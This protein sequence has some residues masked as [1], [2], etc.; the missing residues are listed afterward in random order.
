MFKIALAL[1]LLLMIAEA[2]DTLADE[3]SR[4]SVKLYF[5]GKRYGSDDGFVTSYYTAEGDDPS[6]YDTRCQMQYHFDNKF[7]AAMNVALCY[8]INKTFEAECGLGY[9]TIRMDITQRFNYFRNAYIGGGSYYTSLEYEDAS[10]YDYDVFNIRPGLNLYLTSGPRFIPYI[11]AR[12]DLKIIR[13]DAQL[14]F[15]KPY[16]TEESGQYYLFIGQEADVEKIHIKGSQVLVGAGLE[17]GI[18]FKTEKGMSF[19]FGVFYDMHLRKAFDDF[20][21]MIEDV[22]QRSEIKNIGYTYDGMEI[23]TIGILLA[24]KYYF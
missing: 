21:D 22:E 5:A 7:G 16:V 2:S 23:T 8:D 3:M 19:I 9:T 18:E 24:L 1:I 17:S 20:G 6:L 4:F 15:A 11:S 13:S 14:L 10:D 12:L